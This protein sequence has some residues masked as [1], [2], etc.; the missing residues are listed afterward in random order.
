MQTDNLKELIKDPLVFTYLKSKVINGEFMVYDLDVDDFNNAEV[1]HIMK[2]W[3]A[4]SIS[5]E[6]AENGLEALLPFKKSDF[7]D[8]DSKLT[9]MGGDPTNVTTFTFKGQA[10]R[11]CLYHN[12]WGDGEEFDGSQLEVGTFVP[13]TI[14]EFVPE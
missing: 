14:M 12:S 8:I 11:V 5:S 1:G 10:Y 6:E 7:S 3:S 2:A 13:K 9:Y 4:D